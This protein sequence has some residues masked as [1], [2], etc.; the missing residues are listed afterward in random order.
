MRISPRSGQSGSAAAGA[1]T[2]EDRLPEPSRG[3]RR[4]LRSVFAKLV[5][6]GSPGAARGTAERGVPGSTRD[7]RGML[8]HYSRGKCPSAQRKGF[9]SLQLLPELG[10][11]QL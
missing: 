9:S 7:A 6:G 4:W 3:S 11:S 5:A 1:G 2:G 10:E 8:S